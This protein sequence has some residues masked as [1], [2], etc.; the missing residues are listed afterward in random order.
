MAVPSFGITH[1]LCKR[2]SIED[3]KTR[4][5]VAAY[6]STL[7]TVVLCAALLCLL[8]F[9]FCKNTLKLSSTQ[10][11]LLTL[12][13]GFGTLAFSY[14]TTFYCHLP[15]AFFSF[16]SFVLLVQLKHNGHHHRLYFF[17]AGCSAATAVLIEPSAVFSLAC[18]FVYLISFKTGRR[19]AI[20]FILGCIPPGT[21]Q[22]FYNTICFGGPFSTSYAYSNKDVMVKVNGSLFG[23]A[24]P[25]VILELLMLPYRGLL[26]SSPVLLMA[27]PGIWLIFKKNALRAEALVCLSTS[28]LLF[29]FIACTYAWYGGSSVGPRYLLP[30]FP[31]A[32][33][34]T[35]FA[36][37]KF[38]RLFIL[39]GCISIIINLSI[40]LVGN[41]IPGDVKNPLINAIAKNIAAGKVSINPVPFSHFDRYSNIYQLADM[42]LWQPNFNSFNLG[43]AL[44]PQNTASLLPLLIFWFL[45]GYAWIKN[46]LPQASNT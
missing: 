37:K 18:I 24:R 6:V 30:A 38:P 23:L 25:R 41:E 31:F 42:H 21:V 12:F 9:Y 10:C 15:A 14:S 11:M 45:W 26:V 28:A 4:V 19:G 3:E 46:L 43:E 16:L 27:L 22:C 35:A 36:I 33:M 20:F 13:W 7:C 29:I 2:L 1:Y 34:L 44:F 5:L 8:I 32:F 17:L 40:T 39:L